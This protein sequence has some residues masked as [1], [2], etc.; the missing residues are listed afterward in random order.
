MNAAYK[1]LLRRPPLALC[2]TAA[3]LAAWFCAGSLAEHQGPGWKLFIALALMLGALLY[4][5]P[6]IQRHY[7]STAVQLR[8]AIRVNVLDVHYQPIVNL[9]TGHVVGAEALSRW[10]SKGTAIPSDT[11]IAAAEK[12]D[13]ACELTRSVIRRVAED[14]CTYLWACKDFYITISLCVQ[15]ILDPTFPD[16]VANIMATYNLPATAIIFEVTETALSDPESAATQLHRLRACGHRIAIANVGVDDF[17][18]SLIKFVPVDI[19]KMD[20]TFITHDTIATKDALWRQTAKI[21]RSLKLNVIAEGVD[22]QQQLLHL[23]SEG[24]VLAQGRFFA[25][26]LPVRALARRYFQC[27]ASNSPYVD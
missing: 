27:P 26:E 12:S 21:A 19:L 22:T 24:V 6:R 18:L 14:Y 20:L 1:A 25:K 7:T 17:R 4:S 23:T 13:L 16:F 3:G 5:V 2:A 8:K 10:S 11:F 9:L 15:D